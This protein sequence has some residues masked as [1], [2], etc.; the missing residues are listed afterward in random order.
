MADKKITALTE[1]TAL[2]SADLFHVVDSPSSNPSNQKVT[3]NSVFM[4]I[5]APLA[6]SSIAAITTAGAM[7]LTDAITS[8]AGT[9]TIAVTLAAGAVGQF[10]FATSGVATI[11]NV[12]PAA[13]GGA[14]AAIA[15]T[16][17]GEAYSLLYHTT[18]VTGWYNISMANGAAAAGDGGSTIIKS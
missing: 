5:P 4:S 1:N 6:F 12:I 18:T 3:V 11:T 8:L 15:T 10:K 16:E 9:A 13:T 14:Y 2:A 7:V 17:I